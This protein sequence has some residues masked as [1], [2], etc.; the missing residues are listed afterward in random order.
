LKIWEY[1]N[2]GK[3]NSGRN[4]WNNLSPKEEEAL[5][6]YVELF[7]MKE[8]ESIVDAAC[9]VVNKPP[10]TNNDDRWMI[11]IAF[12]VYERGVAEKID[13]MEITN[14]I[15]GRLR[16]KALRDGENIP[17]SVETGVQEF[18]ESFV[19]MIVNNYGGRVP[20]SES[21]RDIIAEFSLLY[22]IKKWNSMKKGSE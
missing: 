12:E 19:K 3:K 13:R 15:A 2:K 8:M 22:H 9:K 21:R 18:A 16:D 6:Y 1:R 4:K 20:R 7:N 14:R 11:D 5:N 10:E 17:Q